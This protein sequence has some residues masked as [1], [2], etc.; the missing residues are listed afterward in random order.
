MTYEKIFEDVKKALAK[1]DAKKFGGEFAFQ[2]NIV[3]EGEGAFYVAYKNGAVDIQPYDYKG[4]TASV[5]MKGEDLVALAKGTLSLGKA[6]D[7]KLIEIIGDGTEL[8][9]LFTAKKQ[10]VT[11]AKEEKPAKKPAAKKAEPKKPAKAEAPKAEVKA[12]APTAEVKAAA[13]TAEV[14]A[15]APKAEVKAAA[16]K[17]EVK[18][19]APKAEV[20]AEAPKAAKTCK[21]SKKSK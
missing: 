7:E 5:N 2:F 6:I 3:G 13:P 10:T 8:N 15:A 19:A 17:A 9:N 4:N 1:A 18:A 11:K 16:P 12:A 14:K 21:T 20:K